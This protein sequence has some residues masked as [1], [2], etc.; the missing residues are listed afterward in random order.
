ME[1]NAPIVFLDSGIGGLPYFEWML[2]EVPQETYI[3][4]ADRKNF[5]YGERETGELIALVIAVVE[6]IINELKP[7][8][9]VIACNT[10]SVVA[11]AKL[12]DRFKIPF[13][14]VVPALKTAAERSHYRRIG[15]LATS[16][17]VAD[18]YTDRLISD[19][20]SDCRVTRVGNPDIVD[21]I[22]RY[23]LHSSIDERQ[24]LLD[25]TVKQFTEASIDFLVIGCTHFIFIEDDLR[26][27]LGQAVYIIDSREG[28]G[29]QVIRLLEKH[30]LRSR[31][32]GSRSLYVTSAEKEPDRYRDFSQMY[33]LT[34]N[35]LLKSHAR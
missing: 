6:Q 20:A 16:R 31:N 10:A 23:F 9:V 30:D 25:D 19:Y 4:V 2:R 29:K 13:V 17:T 15:L 28:V 1:K 11:L 18:A 24:D 21:F 35:G 7:K 12:R 32:H 34:F 33:G 14:G 26:K 8:L 27:A 3:Y 22:E 5:P